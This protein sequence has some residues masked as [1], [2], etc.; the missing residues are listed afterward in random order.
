MSEVIDGLK[1][2]FDKALANADSKID[3][4]KI[5]IHKRPWP[6]GGVCLVIGLVLGATLL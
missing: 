3:D 5:R 6:F 4:L 2:D 1:K